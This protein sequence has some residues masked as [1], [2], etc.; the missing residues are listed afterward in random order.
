[1]VR[2]K[3]V[4][5]DGNIW[6]VAKELRKSRRGDDDYEVLERSNV[7]TMEL[8]LLCSAE[9]NTDWRWAVF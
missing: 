5:V 3:Q 9:A 2:S 1:V 6:V 4:G 8:R 7:L